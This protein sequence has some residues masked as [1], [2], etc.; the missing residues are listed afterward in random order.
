MLA[1]P[2]RAALLVLLAA[3][4]LAWAGCGSEE[5]AGSGR[6]EGK[7]AKLLAAGDVAECYWPGDEQTA[8]VLAREP[9]TIAPLGDNAYEYGTPQQYRDCYGPS[10]GRFRNRTR[11]AVGGHDYLRSRRA[12]GYF[13]YFGAAAHG[14]DGWYSY[15][16]G[17][18]HVIVLNAVCDRAGGCDQDSP[19]GQWLRTDLAENAD[20]KCTLAYWHDAWFTSGVIHGDTSAVAPFWEQLY[21]AGADVVL[22]GHE[23]FY[24]RFAP[25]TPDGRRDDAHGLRQFVVGTGGRKRYRHARKPRAGSEVLDASSYGVLKLTLKPGRYAWNFLPA[26]KGKF[27]DSGSDTCH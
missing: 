22:S 12:A 13:G 19:Q 6:E 11:P 24:E 21:D 8:K 25:M 5:Q 18:W 16:L 1:E 4:V 26:G 20:A 9:G 14:P 7:T 23:H 27:R 15:D 17:S 2:V 3:L 10:W